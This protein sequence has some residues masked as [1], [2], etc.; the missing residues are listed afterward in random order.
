[1]TATHFLQQKACVD[2]GVTEIC[3]QV[4]LAQ[5]EHVVGSLEGEVM[6]LSFQPL[7]AMHRPVLPL[8][9]I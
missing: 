3:Y 5:R 6:G 1:M 9:N 8:L 4:H 2:S 7:N